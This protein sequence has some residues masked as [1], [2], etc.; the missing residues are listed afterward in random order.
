MEER[1]QVSAGPICGIAF[2]VN[3]HRGF[4]CR[5]AVEAIADFLDRLH[6]AGFGSRSAF[7]GNCKQ[8]ALAFGILSEHG[9]AQCISP[10]LVLL[11]STWVA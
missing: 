2:I 5:L 8:T 10:R 4:L 6:V 9:K 3:G 1:D 7:L 11:T